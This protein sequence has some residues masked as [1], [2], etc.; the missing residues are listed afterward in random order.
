MFADD[1]EGPV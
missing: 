1:M